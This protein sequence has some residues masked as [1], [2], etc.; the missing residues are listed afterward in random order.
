MVRAE[1]GAGKEAAAAAGWGRRRT[2]S[3]SPPRTRRSAAAW[4]P[5]SWRAAACSRA[6]ARAMRAAEWP[7]CVAALPGGT[8]AVPGRGRPISH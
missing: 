7:R 4:P 1:A 3:G 8:V 5:G 6:V 2:G